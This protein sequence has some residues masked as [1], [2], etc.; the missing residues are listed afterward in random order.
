M[1]VPFIRAYRGYGLCASG[2][3]TCVPT[4]Y[5]PTAPSYAPQRLPP[6]FGEPCTPTEPT[7]MN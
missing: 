4:V 1:S 6:H 3:Q 7:L 2:W 5:A